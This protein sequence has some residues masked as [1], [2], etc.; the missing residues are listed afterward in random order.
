MRLLPALILSIVSTLCGCSVFELKPE[1]SP[2]KAEKLGMVGNSA[3][4][5]HAKTVALDGTRVF[6]GSFNFDPRSA[7]LNCEMGFLVES[8]TLANRINTAFS[9][10]L[11]SFA[12]HVSRNPAGDLQWETKDA[13][14]I[15]EVTS[16]E[17]GTSFAARLTLRIVSLLPVEWM[18]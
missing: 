1:L 17:P 18:L 4:S 8:E 3:A 7:F 12:W 14:G 16:D 10:D 13:S 11:M 15:A 9:Q 2:T 5:L 6:V